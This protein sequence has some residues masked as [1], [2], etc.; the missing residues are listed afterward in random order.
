MLCSEL[1]PLFLKL[2][3]D[4]PLF[5]SQVRRC[6]CYCMKK[7]CRNKMQACGMTHCHAR[8]HAGAPH[9]SQ[10][11][12]WGKLSPL[13]GCCSSWSRRIIKEGRLKVLV[14]GRLH[15]DAPCHSPQSAVP[16]GDTCIDSMR[17]ARHTAGSIYVRPKLCCV[18][19]SAVLSLSACCLVLISQRRHVQSKL[20]RLVKPALTR[21]TDSWD[22]V[23]LAC[24]IWVRRTCAPVC[25]RNP[26]TA[27]SCQAVR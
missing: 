2:F 13:S 19:L 26:I 21:S 25:I 17:I 10:A 7:P 12:R 5:I 4:V 15:L 3:A 20:K 16:P 1:E 23:G 6:G 8:I 27:G 22:E 24:L 18:P 11:G 9:Q 14:Q